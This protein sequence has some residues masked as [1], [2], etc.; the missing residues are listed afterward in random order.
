MDQATRSNDTLIAEEF[1]HEGTEGRLGAY[2]LSVFYFRK[3]IRK[4][5]SCRRGNLFSVKARKVKI[6]LF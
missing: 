4:P 6:K 5:L 3:L 1:C 2:F